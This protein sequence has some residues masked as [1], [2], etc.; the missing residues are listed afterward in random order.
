MLDTIYVGLTGLTGFSEGLRTISNNV[1]NIN[2]PGFKGTELQFQDLFYRTQAGVNADGDQAGRSFGSGLGAGG[3]TILFKQGQLRQTGNDLDAAI[4][5]NGFYVLR[6][7]GKTFFTRAGQFTFDADGFLVAQ[8]GG[9]R[10]QGLVNGRLQDINISAFKVS[11]AGV[12]TTVK[13]AG[14]LSVNDSDN[15]QVISNLNVFD[16]LG[17]SHALTV[18]LTNNGAVTP[19]S[20]LIRVEDEA[21][22]LVDD[23]G[24]IRFQGDGSP[25]DGF[26]TH[27]FTF[28]PVGGTP[29]DLTLD[30]G[31]PGGFSGATNFSAG[32]DS[33]LAVSSQDGFASG[34][35]TRATFDPDG[36]LVLSY[37]NAQT[38][39]PAQ[40]ALAWFDFLQGLELSGGNRFEN[41]EGLTMRLGAAQSSLFGHITAGSVEG[42]NVDL[43]QEFTDL[44]VVQRGYQASSQVI[45]VANEM[46]QQLLDL[47][48]QRG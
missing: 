45:S 8:Q 13:F 15:Q 19:R 2:T 40:L 44:I 35:L 4:E 39:K 12:T 23:T 1:A 6:Q 20:W 3:T 18:T 30:F 17:G 41:N 29:L 5:G 47:R 21:G 42:A 31:L 38:A 11:K 28:V 26:T 24:E 46:I 14:N 22:N 37:S 48:G 33:T 43:G 10:V 7:D 16:A 9:A 25:L 32:P 27:T 36:T 34:A